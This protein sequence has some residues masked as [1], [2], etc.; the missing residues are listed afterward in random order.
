MFRFATILLALASIA[1]LA[2]PASA[3]TGSRVSLQISGLGSIPFG[4]GLS[5]VEPGAGFE[6]QLRYSPGAFSI[7]G[8]FET[9]FHKISDTDREVRLSGAF[10]EPR[11]VIDTGSESVAPYLSARLAVSQ[12]RFTVARFQENANGFTLNAGGGLLFI[13][14]SRV[15]LDL[16]LTFGVKDLGEATVP[17]DPPTVF[18]L[19][20]G[21][22][23]IIRVGLA[24]GLG[25]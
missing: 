3:Q 20:S 8:G 6:A 25:G 22:N 19:G 1:L 17:S 21:Q 5:E 14:S 16:G 10:I 7:G 15:N 24:F 13:L 2:L 11:Y 23:V 9:S 18:D 4:G 12:V